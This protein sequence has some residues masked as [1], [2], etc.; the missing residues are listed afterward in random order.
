MVTVAGT[1]R[2]RGIRRLIVAAIILLVLAALVI[3][4]DIAARAYAEEQVAQRV[5]ESLPAGATADV[6]VAIGG[7]SMLLQLLAGRFDDVQLAAAPLT[8]EGVPV[9]VTVQLG[10]VPV[11]TALPVERAT[12]RV[13][14]TD[15]A[16]DALLAAQGDEGTT[17]IAGGRISYAGTVRI[18]AAELGY[19]VTGTATTDE[20]TLHLA[21]DS[22]RV[23][24][25]PIDLDASVLIGLVAPDGIDYCLGDYLP[26]GIAIERIDVGDGQ[27]SAVLRGDGIVLSADALSRFRG[28]S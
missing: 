6:D 8:V 13:V 10:G 19:E 22:A 7:R 16:L 4:A 17:T 23:T 9:A 26:E 20:D 14:L 25:G 12:G 28:C 15:E 1:R 24:A 27:A 18:F 3:A 2:R 11:D 5:E 21:P